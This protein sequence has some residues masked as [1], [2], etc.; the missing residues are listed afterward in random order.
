MLQ[1]YLCSKNRGLGLAFLLLISCAAAGRSTQDADRQDRGAWPKEVESPAGRVTIYEPQLESL[2][3]SRLVTR[4]AVSMIPDGAA[5]PLF[6]ALWLETTLTIDAD[7]RTAKASGIRISEIRF[8]NADAAALRETAA[9]EIARWTPVYSMDALHAELKLLEDR[10][11]AAQSLKAEI[12]EIHFRS[13]PAVL[14]SIDGEPEWRAVAGSRY[15]RVANGSFFVL[16][17]QD[18][19]KCWLHIA[20]FWWTAASVLGPWQAAEEVPAEVAELWRKEPKPQADEDDDDLRRPEVIV[21][22]KPAELVW[23]DGLP[24][25]AAIA[26][27]N[28]LYVKNTTSDVFLEISTQVSYVLLSGRWFRT[29][30]AKVAWEFVPSDQLPLDFSRIPLSSEK[31]H[32]LACVAG[33]PQAKD[34]VKSSGVPQTEGVKPGPAP[35][36][37]ATYDGE[38]RFEEISDSSVSYAVNSPNPVFYV[39]RRYYWCNDGIWYDSGYAVGPWYVCTYV[40]RPIYLIPPSCPFYYVTYCH[41]FSVTPRAIYVGYY[42]GYRGCYVWG[43]TVVYGTGWDYRPWRG[44][45]CY[46]RPSTW[47]ACV[48]Y[49][50]SVCTWTYRPTRVGYASSWRGPTVAVGVGGGVGGYRSNPTV[51]FAAATPAVRPNRPD[52]L[53][54]RQ[55]DRIVRTPAPEPRDFRKQPTPRGETPPSGRVEAPKPPATPDARDLPRRQPS[56][57]SVDAPERRDGGWKTPPSADRREPAPVERRDGGG[58]KAPPPVERREPPPVDRRDGGSKTPAPPP[59][60]PVERRDGGWK[61]PPAPPPVERREPP[62]QPPPVERRDGGWKAPPAPPPVERREP[63]RQPP[64]PPPPVER[65]EPPRQPPPPPPPPAERRDGGG[66]KQPP[67]P[68]PDRRR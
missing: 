4:A 47:N 21:S 9:A 11:A 1:T 22:T 40:P 16:E 37:R 66:W 51:G 59:P 35:D 20:P 64:P 45:V 52:N 34:A 58:W 29:E 68:P 30:S 36:L 2:Q 55:P 53:Y 42:P 8:P 33:T 65:R 17:E 18:A 6:G 44:T 38:P 7:R 24:Q 25:Y 61:A 31:H 60:P 19:G 14:L 15:R 10:K 3:G 50:P 27:T 12:P 62:R 26:G 39:D 43:R 32:V 48:R 63:P 13:H 56:P 23:T 49:S 28:L 46:T 5:E 67:S 41:I 57:P 54:S